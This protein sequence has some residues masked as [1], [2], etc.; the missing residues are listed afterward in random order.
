MA[1]VS[2]HTFFF[3]PCCYSPDRAKSSSAPGLDTYLISSSNSGSTCSS[4]CIS[5]SVTCCCCFA[6]LCPRI[7]LYKSIHYPPAPS[8]PYSPSFSTSSAP[9]SSGIHAASVS[10]S[11]LSGAGSCERIASFLCCFHCQTYT[12]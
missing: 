4:G 10:N 7:C 11:R 6:S 1:D 3:L 9:Y 8:I 12:A 5:C 2:F